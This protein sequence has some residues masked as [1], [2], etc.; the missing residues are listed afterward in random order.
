V[1]HWHYFYKPSARVTRLAIEL[2]I[3]RGIVARR[4]YTQYNHQGKA[5]CRRRYVVSRTFYRPDRQ[6]SAS[7]LIGELTFSSLRP[8]EHNHG[9]GCS[10]P[11]CC[12]NLRVI[13]NTHLP[14]QYL[15]GNNP[16]FH[17]TLMAENFGLMDRVWTSAI[18]SSFSPGH[19]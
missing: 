17:R 2:G 14:Q 12:Q 4:E 19:K 9:S 15:L 1:I 11:F 10:L 18:L 7:R 13:P 5:W 16:P 6:S 8:S 3:W